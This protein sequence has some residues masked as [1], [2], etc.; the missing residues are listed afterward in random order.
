MARALNTILENLQDLSG[1]DV[2][3]R[4]PFWDSLENFELCIDDWQTLLD[5]M[6]EFIADLL[7]APLLQIF[8]P[9][10]PDQPGEEPPPNSSPR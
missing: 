6:E 5:R 2:V 1:N 3:G 10:V 8:R 9:S 4:V 7:M